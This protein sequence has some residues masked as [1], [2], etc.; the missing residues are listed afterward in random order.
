MRILLQLPAGRIQRPRHA[1]TFALKI[2][3]QLW[4]HGRDC[5]NRSVHQYRHRPIKII[6]GDQIQFAI[7]V[8]IRRNDVRLIARAERGIVAK[9]TAAI[10]GKYYQLIISTT[11]TGAGSP[12]DQIHAAI[13][14][15]IP[16]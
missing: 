12:A 4:S 1:H 6:R 5:K 14:A 10:V 2:D 7:A 3:S 9:T 15:E 13:A 16:R 8:K 11:A